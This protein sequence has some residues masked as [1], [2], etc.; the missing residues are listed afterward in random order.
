MLRTPHW[1]DSQ[2]A[3]F[4]L[5]AS[6]F[7]SHNGSSC[8]VASPVLDMG[9]KLSKQ[10]SGSNQQGIARKTRDC[11]NHR[12]ANAY[13]QRAQERVLEDEAPQ[14]SE[15]SP[16]WKTFPGQAFPLGVSEVDSGTNF[17]IFSQHATAVTLCLS[18]PERL[19]RVD[20]GMMEFSLDRNV[21]KTGDIWHICIKDLP[22]SNVLYGYR[23]DGPR[24]WH[25]GHRFDSRVVLIDPYAKLVDGRRFFGDTSKKFSK[26]LGTY[27]FD[28]LPFAWGD[29]YK[30][31]NI[32]EKDLVIYEMNVRAFTA[33]ESSGLDPDIRGSYLGVIEK[34]HFRI[35]RKLEPVD[36]R[37]LPLETH[38]WIS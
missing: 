8:T 26:F 35:T 2:V 9:L 1:Y 11:V 16:S 38:I 4:P 31:P 14:I 5:F 18:L 15:T 28:S 36:G 19:G 34:Q 3:K 37:E 17:A 21:N 6:P 29:N 33:S 24:G 7:S 30:L 32:P 25:E 12:T 22:R 27:D 13:S 23:M 20:G 10:V